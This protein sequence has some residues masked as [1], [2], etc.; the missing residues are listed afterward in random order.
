[1][2]TLIFCPIGKK[3]PRIN[4][5]IK[6]PIPAPGN[7]AAATPGGVGVN[8]AVMVAVLV[9]VIVTVD[10]AVVV[11]VGV[12]VEVGVDVEVEV[13]VAVQVGG[14]V[15]VGLGVL[16]TGVGHGMGP[17]AESKQPACAST[18]E[19]G[20]RSRHRM[21][22]LNKKSGMCNFISLPCTYSGYTCQPSLGSSVLSNSC[23]GTS[24]CM[25]VPSASSSSVSAS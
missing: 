24:M 15:L 22:I 4:N 20:I 8:V 21:P 10:V 7:T 17:P 1:L 14:R 11:E 13:G 16:L 18:V 2:V 25:A 5:K 23:S 6:R 19:A 12:E 9:G 3:I